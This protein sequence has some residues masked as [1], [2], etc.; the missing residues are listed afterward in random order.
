MPTPSPDSSCGNGISAPMRSWSCPWTDA[1]LLRLV[2]DPG[3]SKSSSSHRQM[4]NTPSTTWS[5]GIRAKRAVFLLPEGTDTA[6]ARRCGIRG[7][8]WANA[9]PQSDGRSFIAASLASAVGE[10]PATRAPSSALTSNL[11]RAS[12]DHHLSDLAKAAGGDITRFAPIR[13]VSP[14][15]AACSFPPRL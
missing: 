15:A 7:S 14:R 3:W 6:G 8:G 13:G 9:I 2:L 11:G 12:L 1:S 4:Q 5:R 10:S